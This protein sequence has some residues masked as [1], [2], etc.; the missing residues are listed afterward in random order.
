MA[1]FISVGCS[2]LLMLLPVFL[3]YKNA[4]IYTS[5]SDPFACIHIT[6]G[7]QPKIISLRVI[8]QLCS[9]FLFIILRKLSDAVLSLSCILKTNYLLCYGHSVQLIYDVLA[10]Y[11]FSH[12]ASYQP[13]SPGISKPNIS[14]FPQ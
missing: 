1:P 14:T 8:C 7:V 2:V 10:V 3:L 6:P 12:G 13:G 9:N 5:T 11:C 4:S